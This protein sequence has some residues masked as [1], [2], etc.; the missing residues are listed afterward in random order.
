[1]E[2]PGDE[3]LLRRIPIHRYGKG[4]FTSVTNGV[5]LAPEADPVSHNPDLWS[6]L[7]GRC[8]IVER[9]AD[10]WLTT[11]QEAIFAGRILH[12][13][14]VIRLS[15][16][17]PAAHHFAELILE[18][19]AQRTPSREAAD[20]LRRSSWVPLRNG[21]CVHMD[22]VV[23]IAEMEAE[24]DRVLAQ[25]PVEAVLQAVLRSHWIFPKLGEPLAG[26]P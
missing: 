16:E 20:A 10:R 5:W 17:Q 11:R 2:D 15:A 21:G 23:W 9:Y 19:L 24:I 6:E 8:R 4:T 13:D 26:V 7:K 22:Q 25:F 3:D 18:C 1:M 12:R 14:G